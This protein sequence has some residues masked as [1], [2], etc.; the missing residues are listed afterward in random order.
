MGL[1]VSPK[2]IGRIIGVVKA[3]TTRVGMGPFPTEM[4]NAVGEKLRTVGNEFGATTGRPRR[5]GWFDAVI[6]RFAC[7]VNGLDEVVV[8]KLD[9]LS[10]IDR[11]RVGVA[12]EHGG[13]R[14][15]EYPFSSGVFS[16]AVVIYEEL[17]GWTEDISKVTRYRDLP[18]A[19]KAYLERL[20][21]YMETKIS[22]VS[23]GQ[24]RAQMIT[25]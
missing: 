13:K 22:L 6:G 21:E 24:S 14:Y 4:N 7:R 19:A 3:Y 2:T 23:V 12:Y 15:R 1:G 25:R 18:E 10:G 16:N 11:I 8:T 17:D 5:C 9:V 20:E